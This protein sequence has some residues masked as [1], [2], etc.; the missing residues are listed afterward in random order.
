MTNSM[1]RIS[2][3]PPF[4]AFALLAALITLAAPQPARAQTFK[5]LYTFQGGISDGAGPAGKLVLDASGNLYG[6]TEFGGARTLGWGTVYKLDPTTGIETILYSF[7]GGADGGYAYGGLVT[8]AAGNFYGTTSAGGDT[9]C[10]GDG[11]GVV[12]KLAPTGK[13]KVLYQFSGG[14]DGG[15]PNGDLVRDKAGNLYGT[16]YWGPY[17]F[18]GVVFK[19]D[20]K[21]HETILHDFTGL[22][23]GEFP[24]AG[25]FL[26]PNGNLF[27]TTSAGGGGPCFGGCG[28]V[29][30]IGKSGK[31]TIIYRFL[32]SPDGAFP[33][34]GLTPGAAGTF[35]GTTHF[36][37]NSS[38]NDLGPGC[39]TVFKVNMSG[40][41]NL[42]YRFRKQKAEDLPGGGLIL[43]AAGNLYG[44]TAGDLLFGHATSYGTVFKLDTHGNE[45]ILYRFTGGNDGCTPVGDLTMDVSGN[46]YGAAFGCGSTGDGVVFE[47]TP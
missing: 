12:F 44:T 33:Y 26:D 18:G 29:F 10:G 39:G 28:T 38:C 23:D 1:G 43:D 47:V 8:D 40:K 11:C 5:V 20:K 27:G 34:A 31:E 24:V 9:S 13:E 37:G 21:G 16:S 46:L 17:G 3:L 32:A 36:G 14:N 4:A 2:G 25:L 42:L 19:V 22:P 41:E 15:A 35:Y 30:E 45:T 7:T 6:M